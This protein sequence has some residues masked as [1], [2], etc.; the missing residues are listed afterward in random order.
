[1]SAASHDRGHMFLSITAHG[2]PDSPVSYI[3]TALRRSGDEVDVQP[4]GRSTD[5]LPRAEAE[6]TWSLFIVPPE[7]AASAEVNPVNGGDGCYVMVQSAGQW[8]NR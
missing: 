3:P 6:D 5:R 2:F 1:M 7:P 4:S 8:D